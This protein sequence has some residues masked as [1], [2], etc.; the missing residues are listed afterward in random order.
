MQQHTQA[1]ASF[2]ITV[3]L[4]K[5]N[6]Y[7]HFSYNNRIFIMVTIYDKLAGFMP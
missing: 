6:W 4:M 7:F 3:F 1:A 2:I 5:I